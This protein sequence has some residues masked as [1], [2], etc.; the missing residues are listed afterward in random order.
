[1][2]QN[3]ILIADDDADVR[4]MLAV[5]LEAAGYRTVGAKDGH[6]AARIMTVAKPIGMITDVRMPS[7]NGMELCQLARNTPDIKDMAILMVSGN[8]HAYDVDAGLISGA[9]GYLGKPLA[10]KALVAELQTLISRRAAG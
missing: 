5:T 2:N 1:M 3:L 4:D 7:M 8:N 10:P 6:T 9:D